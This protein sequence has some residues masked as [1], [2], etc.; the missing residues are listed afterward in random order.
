MNTHRNPLAAAIAALTLF[1]ALPALSQDPAADRTTTTT[2]TTTTKHHYVYYPEHEIYFAPESKTYFYRVNGSWISGTTLPPE[3]VAYVRSKGV[4]IELDTDKPYERH[5][6][7]IKH[8][9]DHD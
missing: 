3:D 4:T 2:T 6:Y 1:V 5:E 8:Y 9:K 7:V